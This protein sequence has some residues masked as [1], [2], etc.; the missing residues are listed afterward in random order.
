MMHAFVLD[1]ICFKFAVS[2]SK[3]QV[4]LFWLCHP[5]GWIVDGLSHLSAGRWFD[6]NHCSLHVTVSMGK[7]AELH[8]A[9]IFL[10]Y[11]LHIEHVLC[12]LQ[13]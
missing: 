7:Y 11:I 9:C 6:H 1:G 4:G 2:R 13:Y 8:T 3:A 5:T 12:F 10:A